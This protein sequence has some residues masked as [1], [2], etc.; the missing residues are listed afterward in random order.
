M[1]YQRL[2]R[3]FCLLL[4]GSTLSGCVVSENPVTAAKDSKLT[5]VVLG[6]WELTKPTSPL[7]W[8]RFVLEAA[9]EEE[10]KL[11]QC[12]GLMHVWTEKQMDDQ[13]WS[14]DEH[15]LCFVSD[16][17]TYHYANFYILPANEVFDHAKQQD[18][19]IKMILFRYTLKE[20]ELH[21]FF[22]DNEGFKQLA[23]P[24]KLPHDW[25]GEGYSR[26]PNLHATSDQ[27]QQAF[28][29]KAYAERLF[30]DNGDFKHVYRRVAK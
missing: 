25:L 1:S 4:L 9:S 21:V 18:T 20:N 14:R 5:K 22:C 3:L 29:D 19:Q 2:T 12:P 7:A 8:Q 28:K 11:L 24:T 30:P 15:L 16:V 10:K 17:G 26:R 13:S 6:R 27:L 23:D